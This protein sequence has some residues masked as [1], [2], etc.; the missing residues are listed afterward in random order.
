MSAVTCVECGKPLE[1]I[2]VWLA[3]VNIKFLCEDCRVKHRTPIVVVDDLPLTDE[4]PGDLDIIEREE[5][6]ETTSLEE[7]AQEE[8]Q[9]AEEEEEE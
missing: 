6:L 3:S 7:L 9:S 1:K 2:P 4:P 5:G 8:E